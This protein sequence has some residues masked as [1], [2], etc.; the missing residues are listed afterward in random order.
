MTRTA[1]RRT[2]DRDK[3]G[4]IRREVG[5]NVK[6]SFGLDSK[7]VAKGPFDR[8]LPCVKGS[9]VGPWK[10]KNCSFSTKTGPFSNGDDAW[11]WEQHN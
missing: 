7:S 1:V 2:S 6:D 8:R 11:T 4:W 10:V 5:A 9:E 3:Q